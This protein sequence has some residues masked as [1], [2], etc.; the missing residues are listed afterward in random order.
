MSWEQRAKMKLNR[1]WVIAFGLY[2]IVLLTIIGLAYRGI[3]PVNLPALPFYDTLGHFI[4]LGSASYLGHKAL[5]GQMMKLWPLAVTVPLAP[6]IVTVFAIADESLQALS[7]LRTSSLS[8]MTANLVGI[9]L[10]YG[11]AAWK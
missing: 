5:G 6:I 7:P 3:L 9:W 4:L 2:F 11:L 10:F 8:D 1:N